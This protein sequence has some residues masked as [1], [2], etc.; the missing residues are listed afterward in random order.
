MRGSQNPAHDSTATVRYERFFPPVA[1]RSNYGK[2]Y[3]NGSVNETQ[4]MH[5]NQ[6][7][8]TLLVT[9]ADASYASAQNFFSFGGLRWSGGTGVDLRFAGMQ[10]RDLETTTWQ[11]PLDPTWFRIYTSNLGRWL[12]PDPGAG[13]TIFPQRRGRSRRIGALTIY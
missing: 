3:W 11:D 9:R 8:S 10:E 2:Y 6:V 5:A 13:P 1:G 7:G 12:T 4:Y